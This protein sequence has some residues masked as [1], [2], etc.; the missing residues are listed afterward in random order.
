MRQLIKKL[1][2]ELGYEIRPLPPESDAPPPYY[3]PHPSCQIPNLATLYDRVFGRRDH[4]YFVEVGAFDGETYSNTSFLAD[5]GWVGLMI[6]PVP[7]FADRAA[8]RHRSNRG[9][10]LLCA[11]GSSAG[12]VDLYMAGPLTTA[13]GRTLTDCWPRAWT[14]DRLSEVQ[15]TVP[16]MR[17]DDILI[18]NAAPV[19]FD[20]LVIDVEGY[21]REVLDGFDL[22]RWRPA[23]M[24]VELADYHPYI[25]RHE[26]DGQI[27]R[28][29]VAA[30][31]QIIF[32]DCV[33]T[34][35][36]RV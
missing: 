16:K 18:E 7:E 8:E 4:G 5:L 11:A 36:R 12:T 15:I 31:Y 19:G 24:I 9:A 3:R 25:D 30:G 28:D 21:E 6:E 34:V 32:K 35:F 27:A 2:F 23:L 14:E 26:S 33:N 13:D 10:K 17:L 22:A 20:L 1:V 29:I